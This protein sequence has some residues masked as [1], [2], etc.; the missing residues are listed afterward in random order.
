V[1]NRC[2]VQP[3]RCSQCQPINCMF[4]SDWID[5]IYRLA[6]TAFQRLKLAMLF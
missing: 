2:Q 4:S 1:E 5:T 6:L 3:L